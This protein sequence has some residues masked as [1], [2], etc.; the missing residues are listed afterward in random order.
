MIWATVS[1][2]SCFCWLYTASSSSATK[3][4]IHLISVLTIWWCP[5]VKSS[6]VLLKKSISM[7]SEVSRQNSVSLYPASFCSPRPNLPVTPG[8]YWLPTSAFQSQMMNR[9]SLLV[10][11]LR[12]LLG[13]LE[14]T[15]GALAAQFPG[16]TSHHQTWLLG[17]SAILCRYLH[18]EITGTKGMPFCQPMT[19]RTPIL[20]MQAKSWF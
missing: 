9:T 12:G 5:C 17:Q 15:H 7:T 20:C 19:L 10:L 3:N 11:V 18:G 13:F 1:S 6:L 4:I 8:I 16:V 2:W 14:L